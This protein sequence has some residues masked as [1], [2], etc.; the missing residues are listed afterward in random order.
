[1]YGLYLVYICL[2]KLYIYT[3]MCILGIGSVVAIAQ[4]TGWMCFQF[5]KKS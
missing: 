5:V 2:Y 4:N 1:M 3:W